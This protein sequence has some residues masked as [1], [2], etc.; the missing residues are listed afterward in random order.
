MIPTGKATGTPRQRRRRRT[1]REDRAASEKRAELNSP[2]TARLE[3]LGR[4][5]SF[6]SPELTHAKR[7]IITKSQGDSILEHKETKEEEEAPGDG[8]EETKEEEEVSEGNTNSEH[9]DNSDDDQSQTSTQSPTMANVPVLPFDP[10]LTH[11]LTTVCKFQSP[12]A[13][14]QAVIEYGITTFDEFRS[15][16]Y[17]HKWEYKSNNAKDI[18]TGVTADSLS[19]VIA[20]ARDLETKNHAEKDNPSQWKREDLML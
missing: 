15:M 8:V 12:S 16:D 11:I 13:P 19:T 20:W 7:D 10:G 6:V 18:L 3:P 2:P 14:I 5:S 1:N 9:D 4:G 17:D